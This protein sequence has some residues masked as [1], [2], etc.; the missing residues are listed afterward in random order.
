MSLKV[1]GLNVPAAG[2]NSTEFSV[3]ATATGTRSSDTMLSDVLNKTQ[4]SDGRYA[5]TVLGLPNPAAILKNRLDG[6]RGLNDTA[7]GHTAAAGD[8]LV[9]SKDQLADSTAV[10]MG[11]LA[12]ETDP[13]K[14]AALEESFMK[15]QNR[16]QILDRGIGFSE[17]TLTSDGQVKR[18]LAKAAIA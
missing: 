14:Q 6:A 17:K 2:G 8:E 1:N 9:Q 4:F 10:I 7:G 13:V 15:A 18:E 3:G 5:D 16:M 11:K 12:K